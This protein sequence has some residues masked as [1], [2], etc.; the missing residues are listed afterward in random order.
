MGTLGYLFYIGNGG[1]TKHVQMYFGL[2]F[3]GSCGQFLFFFLI[4]VVRLSLEGE[5]ADYGQ[6]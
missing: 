6:F 1:N 5:G 3:S 2:V 4:S